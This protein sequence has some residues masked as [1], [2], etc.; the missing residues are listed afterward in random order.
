M[1]FPSYDHKLTGILVPLSA[2]RSDDGIGIGE[3]S[4]LPLLARW[5]AD[6]G[7]QIVQILPVNDTGGQSS[8]Y[9]ALSAFALHPIY[10]RLKDLPEVEAAGLQADVEV[11]R[12]RF[13]PL[14]RLRY[15]EVLAGKERILRA[16]FDHQRDRIGRLP[17]LQRWIAQND[18]IRPYAVFRTIKEQNQNRFW[19]DWPTMRDPT[20]Q[21][22][23]RHWEQGC[24]D[25]SCLYYAWLQL[26]LEQQ[27]QSAARAMENAGVALKGDLPIL[28]SEDSADAWAHRDI[29]DPCFRAGAPPDMFSELGQNWDFPIYNWSRLADS[30]YDWWKRRLQQA[31]K[32]YHAFRIDHVLGFFRIWAIPSAHFSGTLGYFS[33]S[34]YITRARLHSVGFD[35]GRIRWLAEPHVH[36]D[37]VRSSFAGQ[38]DEFI[39]RFFER[40][41]DQDLFLFADHIDGEKSIT[42]GGLSEAHTQRLLDWYRDRALLRVGDDSFAPAWLFR[43]CSRY[44]GLAEQEQRRFERLVQQANAAAERVWD[45]NGRTLLG[46]MNHTTPMLACAEDLGVIPDCVPGTLQELGILGLRVP[47]WARPDGINYRPISR[48]PEATVCAPSVH[49]TSTLRQ[50]W[51]T[52][53]DDSERAAIL[54]AHGINAALDREY[55]PQTAWRFIEALLQTSSRICMFQIQDVFATDALFRLPAAQDERVNVPGTFNDV[56]WTYRMPGTL[57]QLARRGEIVDRLRTLV[58]A[59]TTRSPK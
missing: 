21:Q 44:R 33:P 48:F 41:E 40:L 56:N 11:L 37:A 14:A 18:W 28:M 43:D 24:G 38:A 57:E 29:F 10:V 1:K 20:P 35:D 15:A 8:P 58:A 55:T 46:F 59:R 13:A 16:A 7:A 17:E 22:I 26:R 51:E 25:G 27:L 50:W 31:D 30:D 54:T 47:R 12:A 52:E 49:D 23:D 34:H 9:S 42:G 3:F 32:F 4:D 6:F 53:V 39:G 5:C 2:L 19:H 36:G 45:K